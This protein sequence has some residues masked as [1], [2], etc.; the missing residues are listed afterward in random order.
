MALRVVHFPF[1]SGCGV[2]GRGENYVDMETLCPFEEESLN[3]RRIFCIFSAS[4]CELLRSMTYLAQRIS[5]KLDSM[6]QI[7]STII[8]FLEPN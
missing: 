1:S 6:W 4:I 8:T 7:F 2:A 5:I 3:L